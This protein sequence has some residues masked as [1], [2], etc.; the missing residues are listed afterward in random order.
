LLIL[1]LDNIFVLFIFQTKEVYLLIVCEVR[2][3]RAGDTHTAILEAR[4]KSLFRERVLAAM[5]TAGAA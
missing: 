2:V 1:P 4:A 5:T 3:Q